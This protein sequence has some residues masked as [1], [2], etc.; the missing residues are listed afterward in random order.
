[1]PIESKIERDELHAIIQYLQPTMREQ[2]EAGIQY[3]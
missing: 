2:L 3:L 1:M